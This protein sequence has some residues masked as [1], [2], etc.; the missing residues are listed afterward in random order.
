MSS[1]D[2]EA[3][4]G[5]NVAESENVMNKAS[6]DMIN[7][8]CHMGPDDVDILQLLGALILMHHWQVGR[9][10]ALVGRSASVGQNRWTIGWGTMF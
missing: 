2:D 8:L 9:L 6:V 4:I 5:I 7:Y 1:F 3:G 10:S